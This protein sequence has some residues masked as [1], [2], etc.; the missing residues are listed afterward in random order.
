MLIY[1][2]WDSAVQIFFV[3]WHITVKMNALVNSLPTTCC[4]GNLAPVIRS[5]HFSIQV[6][7]Q[8]P[9]IHSAEIYYM[10]GVCTHE[11]KKHEITGSTG[12]FTI[13]ARNHNHMKAT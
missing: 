4:H 8:R 11:R 10:S 7:T 3:Q 5:I 6:C 12:F 1:A 9:S 13:T 2:S